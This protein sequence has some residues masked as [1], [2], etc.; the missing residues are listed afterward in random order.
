MKLTRLLKTEPVTVGFLTLDEI[1]NNM[2]EE[3]L[4]EISS[5]LSQTF[6]EFAWEFTHLNE[7]MDLEDPLKTLPLLDKA[8]LN[9]LERRWAFCFVVTERR[10]DPRESRG[11]WMKIS[12]SHSAA[13]L[14]L[15]KLA[16]LA[17][18]MELARPIFIDLVEEAFARLNGLQK[19]PVNILLKEKAGRYFTPEDK[20]V[21]IKHLKEVAQVVPQERLREASRI[22]YYLWVIVRHPLWIA[23]ATLSHRPWSMI[24]RSTRLVFAAI[25]AMILSVVTVEFWDLAVNQNIWRTLS[26]GVGLV[27]LASIFVI[28]KHH[29]LAQGG[30]GERSTQMAVFK[31][32]TVLTLLIGFV[33]LFV[34]LFAVNLL[35]TFAIFP[36]TLVSKWLNLESAS[37]VPVSN[38]IRVSLLVSCLALAVGA[39]GAGLEESENFRYL[40]YGSGRD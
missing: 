34:T 29:L 27:I 16:P 23:R 37:K 12:I 21:I 8:Y 22:F 13:V 5:S 19:T 7:E 33:L 24:Y 9:M 28:W 14:S 39:L 2:V 1:S 10:M 4:A 40:L 11:G 31:I 3:T 17:S 20:E 35:L 15:H 25:A 36:R 32:S 26:L 18:E 6:P 30:R 38:Y